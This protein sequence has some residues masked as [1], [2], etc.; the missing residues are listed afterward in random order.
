MY[1]HTILCVEI[2]QMAAKCEKCLEFNSVLWRNQWLL[3]TLTL[4][5]DNLLFSTRKLKT[6]RD[7]Q[8][9]ICI[10]WAIVN[11]LCLVTLLVRSFDRILWT[12]SLV[13]VYCAYVTL[14]AN[15]C[16]LF[17]ILSI[18]FFVCMFSVC[19]IILLKM[20]IPFGTG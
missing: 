10:I 11:L 13:V 7:K 2:I 19:L 6:H 4:N 12:C 3:R 20:Q 9:I 18:W 8:I 14:L 16:E 17:G 5:F 1:L 15:L